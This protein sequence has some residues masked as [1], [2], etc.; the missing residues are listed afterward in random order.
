MKKTVIALLLILAVQA[1]GVSGQSF[2][3]RLKDDARSGVADKPAYRIFTSGGKM[4]DYQQMQA[5]LNQKD[6]VFFG[7][8]HN[9]PIAHWLQLELTVDLHRKQGDNMVL[10]AEMFEADDQLILNEYLNGTIR[11]KNF[12]EEAGLWSNYKT[13]YRPLVEYARENALPF[14]ATN[15]P[16]RYASLVAQSGFEGLEDLTELARE[17][18]APL[19]IPYD[20]DLPGYKNMLKMKHMPGM[21]RQAGNL[22]KAQAIKDATMAHFILENWEE[23][24]LFLHYNGTYHSNNKEGIVWYIRQYAEGLQVGTIAT[25]RQDQLDKLSDRNQGVAD[26]ILVVTGNMTKTH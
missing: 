22:P 17:Y 13:D 21:E 25:V 11:E 6:I 4:V 19:P 26:F 8:L 1:S 20:P 2:E 16:R 12:K 15:I 10:G 18:I 5:T 7:E 9:N 14:I 3:G 24:G 23:D